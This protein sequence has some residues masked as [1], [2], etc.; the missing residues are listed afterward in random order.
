MFDALLES[1]I[2]GIDRIVPVGQTMDFDLIWDGYDLSRDLTR[3]VT[4]I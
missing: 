4:K 2:K 3:V 1:G